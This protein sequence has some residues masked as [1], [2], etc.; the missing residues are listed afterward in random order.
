MTVKKIAK[1]TVAKKRAPKKTVKVVVAAPAE[2]AAKPVA[3]KPKAPRFTF[4]RER[5]E[6]KTFVS[7]CKDGHTKTHLKCIMLDGGSR[8][9]MH[10]P[11]SLFTESK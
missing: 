6:G 10:V 2:N 7:I 8:I 11:R 5:F 3:R 9:S 4:K 1:K